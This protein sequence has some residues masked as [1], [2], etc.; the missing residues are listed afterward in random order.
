MSAT[1][2]QP[3]PS[4]KAPCTRTTFLMGCFMTVLLCSKRFIRISRF[5]DA[6]RLHA[7][8]LFSPATRS[9]PRPGSRTPYR[10]AVP[11][12]LYGFDRVAGFGRKIAAADNVAAI[13]RCFCD[14]GGFILP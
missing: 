5:S 4:A 12:K 10:W 3:E 13:R 7:E 9:P 8:P 6:E 1:F 11:A 14:Y 2:L